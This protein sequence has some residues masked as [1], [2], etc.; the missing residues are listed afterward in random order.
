MNMMTSKPQNGALP[1]NEAIVLAE[2]DFELGRNC[3]LIARDGKPYY[4]RRL[5]LLRLE[6][7]NRLVQAPASSNDA[8]A[9]IALAFVS[10]AL[11][12]IIVWLVCHFAS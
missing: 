11:I 1:L 6:E 12:A 10:S 9:F 3:R 4:S 7:K 2:G 8:W 5:I